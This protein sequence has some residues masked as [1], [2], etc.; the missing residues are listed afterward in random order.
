MGIIKA[1][2]IVIK[3]KPVEPKPI[4]TS[5]VQEVFVEKVIK[6]TVEKKNKVNILKSRDRV[7]VLN[8]QKTSSYTSDLLTVEE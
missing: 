6:P 7:G 8:F 2:N 4:E 5:S 1:G 3:N